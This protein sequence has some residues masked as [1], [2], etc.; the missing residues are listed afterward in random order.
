MDYAAWL[1]DP[2]AVRVVLAEVQVLRGGVETTLFLSTRPYTTTPTDSKPNQYYEPVIKTGFEFTE[3]L[4]LDGQGSLSG[5]DIEIVNVNGVRDDWLNFIWDNNNIKAWH[6]D[7]RWPLSEFKMIFNG[8]VASIGC[9]SRDS[10]NI[11]LRD[12]LQRLN[13][14]ITDEKIGTG[15]T[16]DEVINLTFGEVHN[17]APSLSNPVTLEYQVHNGSIED[18]IEVRDNGK[19]VSIAKNLGNGRFTLT[20]ASAGT[21]TASVQGD[22]G[23]GV[24]RNTISALVQRITTGFGQADSRF[25]VDDLDTANLAQFEQSFPQPVGV[26]A[27]GRTNVLSLCQ[28]L[29]ASVDAQL[30]MSRIGK[31]RLLQI[32]MQG[33]GGERVMIEDNIMVERSLTIK[34]RPFVK[35][36][37]MLGFNKCWSVQTGLLTSIPEEHKKL[38]ETEWLTATATSTQVQAAYKLNAAPVQVDTMLQRRTDAMS[39]AQRR[40]NLWSVPRTVFEFEGTTELFGVLE[41]GTPVTLKTK[42]FGLQDGKPGIVISLAHDWV[43]GRVKVGV[44]I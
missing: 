31:L 20:R 37:V 21:I 32:G 9:K 1:K 23:G 24:Y 17:V 35:A 12:K 10:L 19:P 30:V 5:G 29:A 44:L 22:K 3:E 33:N 14:P 6:G 13:T 18:F 36:A 34:E 28:E 8:V 2:A 7:I 26:Y 25:T 40:L 15:A 27:E 4:S 41:L 43:T 11:T 39:E 16:S 42:R 38:Y